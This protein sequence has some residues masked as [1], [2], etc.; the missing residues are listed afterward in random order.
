MID[1]SK[2]LISP[3]ITEKMEYLNQNSKKGQIVIFKVNKKA[4]KNQ[5]KQ[6]I[7]NM[8]KVKVKKVNIINQPYKKT[9]FRNIISKKSGFKKA[10][11][12]LEI[13]SKIQFD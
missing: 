7:Y 10:I 11:L 3:Y 4:T 13:G 1:P 6:A 9:R 8:Y 2:I 5:I 12:Q